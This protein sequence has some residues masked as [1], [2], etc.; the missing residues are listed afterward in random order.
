MEKTEVK[1][2]TK[3]I[4]GVNHLAS[5]LSR[6]Q[7]EKT[8][9]TLER[10]NKLFRQI[11]SELPYA[12]HAVPPALAEALNADAPLR[13]DNL[14]LNEV[15][16]WLGRALFNPEQRNDIVYL[17]HIYLHNRKRIEKEYALAVLP[18]VLKEYD[19]KFFP[20][21]YHEAIKNILLNVME[22]IINEKQSRKI[23]G[24]ASHALIEIFDPIIHKH[25]SNIQLEQL[26]SNFPLEFRQ[27]ILQS[28]QCSYEKI[29]SEATLLSIMQEKE[30]AFN[31]FKD[32]ITTRIPSAPNQEKQIN[33][34]WFTQHDKNLKHEQLMQQ[35]DTF[36]KTDNPK[37]NQG[38][39]SLQLRMH[40]SEKLRKQI[41]LA[42][43]KT[44]IYQSDNATMQAHEEV[45]QA[46]A[47]DATALRNLITATNKIRENYRQKF[48]H[49]FA[50]NSTLTAIEE[51]LLDTLIGKNVV[52]RNIQTDQTYTV[53]EGGYPH[54][55][56]IEIYTS[57]TSS[58][59]QIKENTKG[60]FAAELQ[61]QI[62]TAIETIQKQGAALSLKPV[63]VEE[64][65]VFIAPKSTTTL[66]LII[67]P[68]PE[69]ETPHFETQAEAP[70]PAR[71]FKTPPEPL[72]IEEPI[73]AKVKPKPLP[74]EEKSEPELEPKVT[75]Q[76]LVIEDTD[77]EAEPKVTP[78]PLF[79]E[80]TEFELE[81]KV[82]P[83][84][85]IIT[86]TDEETALDQNTADTIDAG[87]AIMKNYQ[88]GEL[89]Q[90]VL[91]AW[92]KMV[93]TATSAGADDAHAMDLGSENEIHL[94]VICDL[95]QQV[96]AIQESTLADDKKI[97]L[98]TL[99]SQ[100][101]EALTNP[102]EPQNWDC[103]EGMK[104]DQI[105]MTILSLQ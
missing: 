58:L 29:N 55:N 23:P 95:A 68:T 59:K 11:I 49:R 101:L 78:K 65:P 22:K 44:E 35:L 13:P 47:Y 37:S 76:P 89:E 17:T 15:A 32:A 91:T 3:E 12:Q 50:G 84:P 10:L 104:R 34:I 8:R 79:I 30:T 52:K 26:K 64:K 81:P 92:K 102:L 94:Y 61:T 19:L 60:L 14:T 100:L 27:Y 7:K 75:P 93:T 41:Y 48:L 88:L 31:E 45:F 63:L 87:V 21:K 98:Q 20:E 69:V 42:D 85:L 9:L 73:E 28:A 83:K 2:E 36:L 43:Q 80:D 77:F 40:L 97:T 39:L 105:D 90:P 103:F 86:D 99:K 53:R 67:E 54:K 74:V 71:E 66:T 70:P 56:I 5:H 25:S 4:L 72:V 38:I 82:V 33:R 96:A 62:N 24:Y 51:A 46:V 1:Q 18:V 16:V 57:I 6:V